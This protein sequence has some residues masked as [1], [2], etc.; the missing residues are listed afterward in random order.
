VLDEHR[1]ILKAYEDGDGARAA[2]VIRDHL[3]KGRERLLAAMGDDT[4]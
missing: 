4:V 1:A 3:E 2:K